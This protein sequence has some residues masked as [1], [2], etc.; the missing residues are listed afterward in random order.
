M[1]KC[2]YQ[3]QTSHKI[4]R[5]T[6][7]PTSIFKICHLS[8]TTFTGQDVN[9]LCLIFPYSRMQLISRRNDGIL[10]TI[11]WQPTAWMLK[12]VGEK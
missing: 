7:S 3:S 9:K 4:L 6:I 8:P 11:I 1:N 2:R 5:F 12:S 10:K